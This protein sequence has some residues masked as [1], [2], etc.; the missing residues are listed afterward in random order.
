MKISVKVALVIVITNEITRKE[1]RKH[2]NQNTH[3]KDSL[4]GVR[5]IDTVYERGGKYGERATVIGDILN[6]C[7]GSGRMSLVLSDKKHTATVL[8]WRQRKLLSVCACKRHTSS[9]GE[10]KEHLSISHVW[11]SVSHVMSCDVFS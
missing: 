4:E 11:A 10:Q 9:Y 6:Q 7:V 2:R 8:A 3:T 5:K 1:N